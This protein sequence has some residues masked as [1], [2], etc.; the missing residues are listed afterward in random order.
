MAKDRGRT[1]YYGGPGSS[2][3]DATKPK[4]EGKA[5]HVVRSPGSAGRRIAAESRAVA[6]NGTS[7]TPT[8]RAR[9]R[10]SAAPLFVIERST[11]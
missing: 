9:N 1:R 6:A 11:C 5:R 7:T 10:R 3:Q 8:T 4:S 2:H